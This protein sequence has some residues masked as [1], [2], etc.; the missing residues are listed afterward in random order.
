MVWTIVQ[1]SYRILENWHT[2]VLDR[3]PDMRPST[4]MTSTRN[5][6]EPKGLQAQT[7]YNRLA[8]PYKKPA[9]CLLLPHKAPTFTSNME[10]VGSQKV[11]PQCNTCVYWKKTP[12]FQPKVSVSELAV[13]QN[14]LHIFL[15]IN[16]SWVD[17]LGETE[18]ITWEWYGQDPKVNIT[19]MPPKHDERSW[20]AIPQ[21]VRDVSIPVSYTK[22]MY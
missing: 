7:S 8:N 22:T 16:D 3:W 13:L 21:E 10:S 9:W 11:Y 2:I 4:L 15:H 14:R 20:L 19:V 1:L 5:Y 6:M 17:I 18:D 12:A